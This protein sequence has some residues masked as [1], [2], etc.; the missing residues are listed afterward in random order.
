MKNNLSLKRTSLSTSLD[1]R[2]T[3]EWKMQTLNEAELD[4]Q[5][6]LADYIG[7][8]LD[9]IETQKLNLKAVKAEVGLREKD[10]TAQSENI[11]AGAVEFMEQYGIEKLEGN[12]VSSVTVSKGKDATTK[13]KFV[14]ELTK[15]QIEEMVIEAG[16][17]FYEDVEVPATESKVR[18]NK[19]KI[20]LAEVVEDENNS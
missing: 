5:G 7:L 3:L 10:L 6:G 16:F 4:V 9:E 1:V 13:K 18:V 19:R 20:A 15:K 2:S 14:T 17:G 8:S 11:K 12:I